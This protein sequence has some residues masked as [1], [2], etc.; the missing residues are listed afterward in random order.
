MNMKENR[1]ECNA[2]IRGRALRWLLLTL[3]L[4]L[5]VGGAAM[6]TC[7]YTDDTG[8]HHDETHQLIL[9]EDVHQA[10]CTTQGNNA[11]WQC[12][13]CGKY[14]SDQSGSAEITDL[15]TMSI[16]VDPSAHPSLSHVQ[17]V[18]ATCTTTGNIE[19]WHCSQ[20]GAY[21][22]DA[23]A[24]QVIQ[25]Q[26]TVTPVNAS[27]HPSLTNVPA[28]SAKCDAP[29]HIEYWHCDQCGKYFSDA[30]STE[31]AG[32]DLQTTVP[33]NLVKTEATSKTCTTQ[34][35]IAY[36]HCSSCNKYFSDEQGT[37][38]IAADS[39]VIP[40]S[41][42]LEH[43][44]ASTGNC[45]T[46]GNVE[47]WHCTACGENFSDANG[48]NPIDKTSTGLGNHTPVKTD[49]KAATCTEPG[50]I[51]Y[52]QC[53]VCKKYFSDD[54][55][56]QDKEITQ[57]STV[58]AALDHDWDVENAVVTQQFPC[59]EGTKTFTCKRDNT[60]TKTEPV[61]P[62]AEHTWVAGEVT[63]AATT[64]EEGAQ[65]YTCSV[66]GTSES[67]VLPVI[68]TY[69][70]TFYNEDGVTPLAEAKRYEANTPV[71]SIEIPAA[72][73]KASFL[74]VKW[75]SIAD[76]ASDIAP[77]T[78]DAGYKPVYESLTRTSA[79]G[80]YTYV[81]NPEKTE[82]TIIA[83][84][85]ANDG[86]TPISVPQQLDG[87]NV[88]AIGDGVFQ[89]RFTDPN[90]PAIV[91]IPAGV[92]TIGN[93]AFA[94]NPMLAAL[95]LPDTLEAVGE[96]II[97]NDTGLSFLVLTCTQATTL[98]PANVFIHN[99]NREGVDTPVTVTLPMNVTDITVTANPLN[100]NVGNLTIAC[101]FTVQAGHGVSVE[102]GT[103]L[104]NNA[105][106]TNYGSVSVYGTFNNN[107]P[108]Y[109]LGA[110]ANAGA[111][112]NAS[113]VF[114]CYAGATV[115][116]GISGNAVVTAHSYSS[117]TKKCAVCG[118]ELPSLKVK[119]SGHDA[120][121]VYDKTTKSNLKASDFAIED[122]HGM[123]LRIVTSGD[124]TFSATYDNY[125]AGKR[126][127]SVTLTLEGND[128]ALYGSKVKTSVSGNITPKEIT[129]T[130]FE[131]NVKINPKRADG[132]QDK[133]IRQKKV[134]GTSDPDSYHGTASGLWDKDKIEGKLTREPGE[135]VGQYRVLKGT[136]TTKI[137][138]KVSSNSDKYVYNDDPGNYT[139]NVLEGY[140]VIEPKSINASDMGL[141]TIGN[142]RYTGE[143]VKPAITLSYGKTTLVEGKDF[144]AEFTNNVQPGTAT[145]KLT[146]IGN[147]TGTREATFRIL[148][149]ASA[150]SGSGG[151]SG[152][153]S[154]SYSGFDDG[155]GD[156]EE[157]EDEE[158][159]ESEGTL[160]LGGNDYGTILFDHAGRPYSFVQYEEELPLPDD[161]VP[162]AIPD[163][164]LTIVADPLYDE[165]TGET[166][167]LG[168]T[169]REKY[170]TLHLRLTTSLVQTLTGMGYTEL[171]YEL[172]NADL[173]IPLAALLAEI[174]LEETPEAEVISV[175]EGEIDESG[176]IGE[177]V[178]ELE[179]DLAPQVLKV[180]AYDIC[181]EQVEVAELTERE[182]G[183]LQSY[184]PKVP[185]YRVRVRAVIDGEEGETSL[186][187][188]VATTEEGETLVELPPA[189]KLPE[190]TYPIGLVLRVLPMDEVY[191]EQVA[192]ED[193]EIDSIIIEHPDE[194]EEE[195]YQLQGVDAVFISDIETPE[196]KDIVDVAPAVFH[197]IDGMLYA[198]YSVN[199]DGIYCAGTA[200]PEGMVS[201]F[202]SSEPEGDSEEEFVDMFSTPANTL[203]GI[204]TTFT[205]DENGNPVVEN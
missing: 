33:H 167:M 103:I 154:Y 106:L 49:A 163:M 116:G 15:N 165:E 173:H 112:N 97:L 47:Y 123:D 175:I 118:A 140:F 78:A 74:F 50:N 134:F 37:T 159:T 98:N 128:A 174:P 158:E 179:M 31:I 133:T 65:T 30:G 122:T 146:G 39:W 87:V 141:A 17:A 108:L 35:N 41:H 86:I 23:G 114:S 135:G 84:N 57:E 110:L 201:T 99:V 164:Q 5:L 151:S 42:T 198:G 105:A 144:K 183:I 73:E 46:E 172:E 162:N 127:I 119:Y 147:Y 160:I 1:I 10:T 131:N 197:D 205:L 132:T 81:L 9:A 2:T 176:E 138:V 79:D 185:G 171:V 101:P 83:W 107:S 66:C 45:Q 189:D 88:V 25:Q 82:A 142:Q 89:G 188:P 184:E 44:V 38:E 16:P 117:E 32:S 194:E 11:Y 191:T 34:G 149:I 58:V 28:V 21:F 195:T 139:I 80:L 129:I 187:M 193:P 180:D 181:I 61:A 13:K 152:G 100:G 93:N 64:T 3:C 18:S 177:D 71:E 8:E 137:G 48:T 113:S 155:E 190:G 169:E 148:N 104:N 121:K 126:T 67:R 124:N 145:V 168:D 182:T 95:Y 24:T 4:L 136:L 204:G 22:A 196:D 19:Y 7:D 56:A 69:A 120:D 143:A 192:G 53:S 68:A 178:E 70:V 75:V 26:D 29:G 14:F 36:W 102:G 76:G 203:S 202:I 91:V 6:A 199:A 150:A 157:D 94:E 156:D 153:S 170:D 43:V 130:P 77:V 12:S 161:A 63:K 111:F 51:E 90:L 27:A 20:C 125:N 166:I 60:H 109:N 40:A 72:P 85:G 96:N 186:D 59:M 92:R 54:T 55:C 62:T 200:L 52:W 115:S